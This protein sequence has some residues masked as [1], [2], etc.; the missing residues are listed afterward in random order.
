[1]VTRI[2]ETD[3]VTERGPVTASI[4]ERGE[5][6]KLE[7]LLLSPAARNKGNK[8]APQRPMLLGPNN[9]RIELPE[10]VF[11]VLRQIVPQ[12]L[13]GHALTIVPLHKELSTQEAA[14]ILNVSRP[15]LIG[16]LERGEIP[17][18]KTGKHRRI[19]FGDLMA[20]KKKRDAS[21]RKT[22]DHLSEIGQEFG[23]DAYQD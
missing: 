13:Q 18:V 23:L 1:M 2:L 14:D 9:E 22:L 5:L 11:R 20:Y 7:A 10:P 12:L 21:R 15:F 16:L 19:R 3:I 6:E 4:D 8:N 17:F